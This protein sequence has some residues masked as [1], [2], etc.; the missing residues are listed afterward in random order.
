MSAPSSR[1]GRRAR[2][3]GAAAAVTAALA[4][5]TGC[6]SVNNTTTGPVAAPATA[7]AAAFPVTVHAA[8]GAVAV[9]ARPT[10]IVSLSPTATED[11]YAVGAGSQVIAVDESSDYPAG[12][13]KTSLDGVTP[14]AEAILKYQPDLVIV[15]ADSNG[16]AAAMAKVNV[17]VLIEPSAAKLDDAYTQIEQIGQATG[18][19]EA[20]TA[21]AGSMKSQIAAAVA[22]AG[23]SHPDLSYYW[24]LSSPA[25]YYSATSSTFIGQIMSLFGAKDIADSQSTAADGGYPV[26]STEYIVSS[27]PQL[28]FLADTVC[29]GQSGAT[30]A[31]RP[32][33]STIPAVQKNQVISLNDDIASRWGPRLPQLVQQIAASIQK[34]SGQ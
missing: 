30:V 28:I 6:S 3:L 4:L 19:A 27:A 23:A 10:H 24:E 16:L 22:K 21:L 26:L 20:A 1:P 13:P 17:P 11:L 5:A 2:T 15:Q 18:H 8:N 31:T 9:P 14:N 33:W 25:P 29:C 34:A 32:G 12:V 7:G